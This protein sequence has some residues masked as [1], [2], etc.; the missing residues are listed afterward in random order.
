[1]KIT[2]ESIIAELGGKSEFTTNALPTPIETMDGQKIFPVTKANED[3]EDIKKA[4]G[5]WETD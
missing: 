4:K 3:I 2:P 1:M 5:D